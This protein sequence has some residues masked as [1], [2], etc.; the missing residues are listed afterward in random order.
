MARPAKKGLD[1]F[2]HDTDASTSREVEYLEAKYGLIGYALF[3]KILEKIYGHEGY[4]ILWTEIDAS[5]FAKHCGVEKHVLDGVVE[6]CL[7]LDLFSRWVYDANKVLTSASIQRRY[8]QATEKRAKVE[9][10]SKFNL[11]KNIPAEETTPKNDSAG[12]SAEKTPVSVEETRIKSSESTQSKVKE[13]KRKK[14]NKT[15]SDFRLPEWVPEEEWDDFVCMRQEIKKPLTDRAKTLAVKT[16]GEL[17]NAGNEP[18]A[19]L[20]QSVLN[21]WSGLFEVKN[22]AQRK[23]QVVGGN[24]KNDDGLVW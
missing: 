6:I 24:P 13:S 18:S 7:E 16:L 9:I 2:S 1:Y 11:I 23:L 14:K 12:V 3:F 5:I 10:V 8:L 4:Y 19:V 21:S 15:T 17:K 20:K 22:R